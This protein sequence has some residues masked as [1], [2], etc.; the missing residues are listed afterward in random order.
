MSAEADFRCPDV[1]VIGGG[2]A[3]STAAAF[4]AKAKRHVVMLE[5]ETHPRFHVGESLLRHCLLIRW[6]AKFAGA[7]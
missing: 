4:L 6:Q 2:P 3:G 5:K 7:S 1:L